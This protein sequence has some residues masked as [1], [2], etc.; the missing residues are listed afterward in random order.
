MDSLLNIFDRTKDPKWL[1]RAKMAANCAET[2]IYIWNVPMPEDED[3]SKLHWKKG[4]PTVGVQII[5]TGYSTVDQYGAFNP[6]EFARLYAY[7]K[8][9]HYYQVALVLLHNTKSMLAMPG[10][11]YD[12]NGP[13]WQQEFW[14]LAPPRGFSKYRHWLPWI[15]CAHL[16][17]IYG[18]IDF[19]RALYEKLAAGET[20]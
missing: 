1:E 5:A 8:D 10:R 14:S 4:V 7:T 20:P 12:L 3:D 11:E 19:D 16:N 17:G 6:D 18:L 13:G 9:P 2:W 15:T